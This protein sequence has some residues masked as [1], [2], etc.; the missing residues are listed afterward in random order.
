MQKNIT[1]NNHQQLIKNKSASERVGK[2]C[3][4]LFL[5]LFSLLFIGLV[6]FI[7]VQSIPGFKAYGIKNIL[8]SDQFNLADTTKGA[9]VWF[10]LAITLLVSV[11]AILFAAPIGIKTATFIK[12]RIKSKKAQ[13][14]LKI[15]LLTLSGIP[16]VIFGLFALQSL[17]PALSLI[18]GVHS[19]Q[20]IITSFVMLGFIILPTIISLT[21][22]TYDSIDMR[23][24]E[25]GIGMGSSYTRSIYK[26]F[27]KEAKGGIIIA[28][29]ISLGRAL[30]ETMAISMIL[31]DQGYVNV[32]DAGF[33]EVLKSTLRPLGAVISANMFA[34]NGGEELRGLLYVF[35]IVLFFVIMVLNGLV[36]YLT[37]KKKSKY[38]WY[39]KL[40]KAIATFVFFIPNQIGNLYEKLT[41]KPKH[42]L[43]VEHL[44]NLSIFIRDRIQN[45]KF[46]LLYSINKITFET[47]SFLIASGFLVWISLDII[48]NGIG[49]INLNTSTV[50]QYTKNTT[51]QATLNTLIIIFISI[52]IGLPIALFAAIYLNEY[53][54]DKWF[55]KMAIF[56]ID[57]FGATPSIIFGMFG[58]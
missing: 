49:A 32:F 17:G 57:S 38:H 41:Y 52:I 12:F 58:L 22:A 1:D 34:E 27:K 20:N 9:S 28:I 16:S 53:A 35:G 43:S 25:N 36:T 23:L 40:E 48:I 4:A 10:P 56:F 51:G 31:S 8:F 5:W 44:D 54:K 2:I 18:L 37:K 11:G 42:Q 13:K 47:I 30:G 7:I 45:R 46:R 3:S 39:I 55:K 21:L 14:W 33:V 19:A 26:I 29:I 6:I 15:I 24:I 50:V